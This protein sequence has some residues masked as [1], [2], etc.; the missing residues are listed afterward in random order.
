M[1][2]CITLKSNIHPS[3]TYCKT[4]NQSDDKSH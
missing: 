2:Y 4:I 3:N 1:N